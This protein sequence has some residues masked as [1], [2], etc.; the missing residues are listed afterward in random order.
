MPA[1]STVFMFSGQGSQYYQMGLEPYRRWPAFRRH[2]ELMDALVRELSGQSP[3]A[4]M[5]DP[6]RH[7]GET[8]DALSLTHP[9]IFMVEWALAQ[10]LIEQ[11]LKPDMVLGAS[12]GTFVAGALAGCFSWQTALG[13]VVSHARA[14]EDHLQPGCMVAVLGKPALHAEL[15]LA[16]QCDLAAVNFENHFVV[17][18]PTAHLPAIEDFLHRR[19]LSFQRLPIGYPFH[20]RWMDEARAEVE[21]TL[22]HLQGAAT[23]MPLAC[24]A[25]AELLTALPAGHFWRVVREPIHFAATIQR[26]ESQ[27]PHRYID[28]GPSGTLATCLRQAVPAHSTSTAWPTLDPYGRDL[29]NLAALGIA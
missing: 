8:F 26:L 1:S 24:C 28:L 9:A 7:K 29:K 21:A 4:A 2:M 12:L 17:S 3:L 11:G 18:A 15:A 20:S 16:C 5:Y 27:G 10:T 22:G 14:V 23:R 25:A 6:A 13:A 19:E